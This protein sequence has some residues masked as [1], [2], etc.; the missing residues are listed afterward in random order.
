MGVRAV[1][2]FARRAPYIRG[3]VPGVESLVGLTLEVDRL[4]F[5]PCLSWNNVALHYRY[6]KLTTTSWYDVWRS[7]AKTAQA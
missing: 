5:A 6:R 3:Y 7:K 2:H 1:A 4:C